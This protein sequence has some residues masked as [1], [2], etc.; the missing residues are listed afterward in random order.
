MPF[1]QTAGLPP[2]VRVTHSHQRTAAVTADR[3]SPRFPSGA[4]AIEGP[5]SLPPP[6]SPYGMAT[7]PPE[8]DVSPSAGFAPGA[9]IPPS[10]GLTPGVPPL[11]GAEPAATIRFGVG[12]AKIGARGKREIRQAYQAYQS[13][14][15][16]IHVV[17]HASSRTRNLDRTRHELANFR[18]S[19]DRARAVARELIRLG[20]DPSRIVVSAVS[21]HQP[22]FIE[23]MPA[24]EAGNR[25][26]EIIF[27]N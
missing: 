19:Y 1:P 25:R 27:A 12:S 16:R 24:G 18:V 13:R 14:G 6:Q 2:N 15:G 7:L 4:T 10:A 20:V 17:G 9:I 8:L 21:D 22:A 11:P 5:R 3:F 26:A 23:V